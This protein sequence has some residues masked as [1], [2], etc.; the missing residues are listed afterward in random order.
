MNSIEIHSPSRAT[1]QKMRVSTVVSKLAE[2]IAPV[3]I[4][5]K[6]NWDTNTSIPPIAWLGALAFALLWLIVLPWLGTASGL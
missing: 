4:A 1:E 3:D 2:F 5:G 6:G